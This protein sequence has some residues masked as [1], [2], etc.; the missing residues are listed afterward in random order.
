M[1]F[2]I[3]LRTAKA[4]GRTDEEI[5]KR[6]ADLPL[7]SE[8][9]D[10]NSSG[11]QSPPR[12][13]RTVPK[14][15]L[16]SPQPEILVSTIPQTIVTINYDETME[17]ES[18]QRKQMLPKRST[19]VF[20]RSPNQV[21]RIIDAYGRTSS[22]PQGSEQ[23]DIHSSTP[24]ELHPNTPKKVSPGLSIKRNSIREP[25][26]FVKQQGRQLFRRGG[27]KSL[28]PITTERDAGD[29]IQDKEQIRAS[30]IKP[31]ENFQTQALDSSQNQYDSIR[32]K[33]YTA[34]Q[35]KKEQQSPVRSSFEQ[36]NDAAFYA[37]EINNP[38]LEA[39][40]GQDVTL[41]REWPTRVSSLASS[42]AQ[43]EAPQSVIIS[44]DISA[45]LNTSSEQNPHTN[46]G[47]EEAIRAVFAASISGPSINKDA[48]AT[49]VSGRVSTEDVK[50]NNAHKNYF[51]RWA[52]K[53]KSDG[54]RYNQMEII[55]RI[56]PSL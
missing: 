30:E 10:S 56:S 29:A 6:I 32:S 27:I 52:G 22:L 55:G 35:T 51:P 34:R 28:F 21:T 36:N 44:S 24:Y 47:L 7:L 1:K 33:Y 26:Q 9:I 50:F 42:I 13:A 14:R 46:L 2:P 25:L 31:T 4:K 45:T 16:I 5:K 8:Q 15:R 40:K 43:P 54:R 39:P 17:V 20:Y 53:R 48:V 41:P 11:L 19:S 49:V 3:Q 23:D 18:V 38:Y 37:P 12:R